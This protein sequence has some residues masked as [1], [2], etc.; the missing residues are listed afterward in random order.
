[1]ALSPIS[2][3]T[4]SNPSR[5]SKQVGNARHINCFAEE[6]GEE[7]KTQWIIT[8]CPGLANFGVNMGTGGGVRAFIVYGNFLYVVSGQY[9]LKVDAAGNHES[10]GPIAT[11]GPVYMR[12][13]RAGQIGIVSD[14][15]FWVCDEDVLTQ[16]EDADLPSPSALA[17]LDGYGVLP[18]INTNGHYMITA[19]DD[20]TAVDGLDEGTAEADPDPIVVS[21]ELG[22]EVYHFGTKTTEAHQNTGDADFPF[23]RSQVIDVGCSA[24]GS[25]WPV[26]T[27]QGKGLAFIAHDHTVRI[28]IGYATMVIST[29]E[30]E[31]LIRLMAEAGTLDQIQA[32]SW[33]W[34]GRSFYALSS[35]TWTR[36]YD[37][38]AGGWHERHSYGSTR[39]R[40]G[41]V[42][43]FNGKLIAGDIATGQ[44]YQMR[45]DLYDEAGEALIVSVITP[46]VHGFPGGGIVN[47]LHI[48]AV[49]G[50]GLNSALAHLKTPNMLV[51]TAKDGGETWMGP[52][53][54]ALGELAQNARRLPP[55]RRLGSFGPKGITFR[56]DIPA[57]VQRV[58]MSAYV[59]VEAL[60]A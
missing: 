41:K 47:A 42:I 57:P 1:M 20:F 45:D 3:G 36:V 38:K 16:V 26:D 25:V 49:S 60:A 46:P 52:R 28:I 22:R 14:G 55:V 2:L 13:N 15:S 33:S 9:L 43:S 48:D 51:Y 8:A 44:L 10:I 4:R 59:D 24:K 40:V 30:I 5:H 7:G 50:V 18:G 39:W 17:Y 54:V 12:L 35:N 6:L 19:I 11:T 32:T 21:H 58:I 31:N 56:F 53:E 34:G 29:G 27:P 23:T 37:C